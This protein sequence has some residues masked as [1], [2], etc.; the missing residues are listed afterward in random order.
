MVAFGPFMPMDPILHLPVNGPGSDEPRPI[1][2]VQLDNRRD[3]CGLALSRSLA[4]L[5]H[6][7][8]KQISVNRSSGA[9]SRGSLR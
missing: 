1:G 7:R 2:C 8:G 4:Q 6:F 5:N 3:A 9:V